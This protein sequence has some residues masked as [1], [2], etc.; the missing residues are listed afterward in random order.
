MRRG[1][2]ESGET[3]IPARS[4]P[5]EG[6]GGRVGERSQGNMGE[7]GRSG[8]VLASY[9]STSSPPSAEWMVVGGEGGAV[10]GI[11]HAWAMQAPCHR[12]EPDSAIP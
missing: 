8:V 12:L 7:G 3:L 10:N 2:E 6:G 1:G 11:M 5:F 4:P 9:T